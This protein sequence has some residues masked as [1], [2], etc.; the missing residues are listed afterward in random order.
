[1]KAG[2]L[3]AGMLKSLAGAKTGLGGKWGLGGLGR[4]KQ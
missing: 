3:K 1:M 2:A 4:S